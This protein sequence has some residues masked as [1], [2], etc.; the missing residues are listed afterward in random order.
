M[1][2]RWCDGARALTFGSWT[3]SGHWSHWP[4]LLPV[5]VGPRLR[6]RRRTTRTAEEGERCRRCRR[7]C[8]RQE[9]WRAPPEPVTASVRAGDS[10]RG[11]SRAAL[12]RHTTVSTLY[13]RRTSARSQCHKTVMPRVREKSNCMPE[14]FFLGFQRPN[15]P[16]KQMRRIYCRIHKKKYAPKLLARCKSS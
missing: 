8:Q 15:K 16:K 11:C 9:R 5:W 4:R 10:W 6:G 13:Y 3:R 2:V 12:P 1:T 7:R 14:I